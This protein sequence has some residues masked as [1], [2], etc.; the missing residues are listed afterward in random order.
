MIDVF[1]SPSAGW[2][3]PSKQVL[4]AIP[5]PNAI[6]KTQTEALDQTSRPGTCPFCNG[7]KSYPKIC[8]WKIKGGCVNGKLNT[9][10]VHFGR[11][12][13]NGDVTKLRNHAPHEPLQ[14]KRI[15]VSPRKAGTCRACAWRY[16]SDRA[17]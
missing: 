16:G 7:V 15:K 9:S 3:P 11:E 10:R 4:V 14:S 12:V 13:R 6:G 1:L 5:H 2:Q 17:C 8:V